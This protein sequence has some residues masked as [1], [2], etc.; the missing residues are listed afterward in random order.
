MI[1]LQQ[2]TFHNLEVVDLKIQDYLSC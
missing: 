2:K 1:K